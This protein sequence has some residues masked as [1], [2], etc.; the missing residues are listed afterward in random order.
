MR[1]LSLTDARRLA[2]V[3]QGLAGPRLD[4]PLAV[5]RHLGTV[6]VDPTVIVERAE[7]LTLFSRCGR[8][9]RDEL[10]R[11]LEE[12]PRQL[13][14]YNAFL[15]PTDDLPLQRAAMRRFPRPEYTRGRYIAEWLRDNAAFRAYVLDELRRRGPLRTADLD[16]RAEVPWD[17]GGW[18][19]GKNVGRIVELLWRAGEIAI[20]RRQGAVRWWDLFDRVLPNTDE[21]ELPDEVVAVELME[22]QLRTAGLVRPGWGSAIDYR[23]PG[24]D[25]AEESLRRDGIAQPAEVEGLDG[26]WLV[27]AELLQQLDAGAWEPRTVLL[28]PFDPLIHDRERTEALFGFRFKFELYVPAARREHG[29]YTLALLHGERLIGRVDA[30]QDRRARALAVRATWFEPDAPRGRDR[31][32]AGALRELAD[33]Q[34]VELRLPAT[35]GS[36]P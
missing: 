7:R 30:A 17:T 6:Q 11:L 36:G 21:E 16:D 33:W 23:L 20:A 22:R 8:Y 26:P 5:V 25:L 32:M 34:E 24:R 31:L 27:H 18:N 29:P 19:D 14:E 3:G 10:R 12:P 4:G 2:V 35:A 9:D 15:I 1:T 13:F 28:G